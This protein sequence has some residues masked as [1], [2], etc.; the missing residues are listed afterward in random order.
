MKTVNKSRAQVIGVGET[1]LNRNIE[2]L[3][4]RLGDDIVC[5][6]WKHTEVHKRT[7]IA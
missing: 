7:G 1:P 6:V 2:H 3:I 5:T 4:C